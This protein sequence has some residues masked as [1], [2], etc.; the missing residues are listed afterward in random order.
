MTAKR[1]H[2]STAVTV[3]DLCHSMA[4]IAPLGLAESWD[5]VGLLAGDETAAVRKVL[6]CIDLTP[7]VTEEAVRGH[8]DLLIAY[9]P[10]IYKPINRLVA[11]SKGQEAVLHACIRGG[12]A[13]YAVH[14]AMDAAAGGTNDVLADLCGIGQTEPL[15]YVASPGTD[16]CKFV[17]FVPAEHVEAVAEAMFAA[18]AGRIGEYGRCSY[19][20]EG[21]GTFQGSDSTHP[22]VGQAGVYEQVDEIRIEMVCPAG[23]TPAVATALRSAHPY[24]EPA[25]DIYPLKPAPVRGAGRVGHLPKPL[26]LAHLARRLKNA[27]HSKCTQI[28]GDPD[29]EVSR[30]VIMVGAA[31]SWPFK[32]DLTDGDVVVTGEIRHHDALAILRRNATAIALGHWSSERPVLKSLAQRL[33]EFHPSLTV[34]VSTADCEPFQ[35]V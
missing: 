33:V 16:D 20:L 24:E 29:R 31:G 25:F 21:H 35:S 9:H 12:V 27:T 15:E 8:Y 23:K 14:T 18:G 7:P 17:T 3:N 19:R 34:D 6:L 5:N 13:V 32:A 4:Q 22:A 30:A 26:K 2:G 10:P 28:V 11:G 1:S